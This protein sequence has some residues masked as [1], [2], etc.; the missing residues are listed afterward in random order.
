MTLRFGL[1][2]ASWMQM[3]IS[4]SCPSCSSFRNLSMPQAVQQH[5]CWRRIPC[6]HTFLSTPSAAKVGGGGGGGG[7]L[8]DKCLTRCCNCASGLCD[9]QCV[10]H[11]FHTCLLTISPP[12]CRFLY[13]YYFGELLRMYDKEDLHI[14][15]LCV[16][17][18]C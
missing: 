4:E 12:C 3:R 8:K 15:G 16:L 5:H 10:T 17:V 1:C 9:F 7:L 2:D 6:S 11:L 13:P 18:G 14:L